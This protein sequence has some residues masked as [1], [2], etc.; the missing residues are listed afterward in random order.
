MTVSSSTTMFAL[1]LLGVPMTYAVNTARVF[2]GEIGL[3]LAGVAALTLMCVLTYLLV[4]KKGASPDP[5]FYGKC[6]KHKI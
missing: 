4:G 5:L 1:S 3:F 2:H 6:I